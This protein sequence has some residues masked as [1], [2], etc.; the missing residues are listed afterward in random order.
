MDKLINFATT[1]ATWIFFIVVVFIVGTALLFVAYFVEELIRNARILNIKWDCI[2]A[3]AVI[4]F[5]V[6]LYFK[7]MLKKYNFLQI[8]LITIGWIGA[9]LYLCAT[10]D[11]KTVLMLLAFI[12][13]M[14]FLENLKKD[15][16]KSLRE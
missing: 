4:I 8:I 1:V 16:I 7:L 12:L 11:F 6:F 14:K 9:L 15:I 3:Y 5:A 10:G 2:I 13:F